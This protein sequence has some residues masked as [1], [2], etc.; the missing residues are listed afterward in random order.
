MHIATWIQSR[1]NPLIKEV[2]ALHDKKRRAAAGLFFFEG[3]K[4]FS[5]A[6]RRGVSL[7]TV[8]VTPMAAQ[9]Y[10]RVLQAFVSIQPHAN[11]VGV[12]DTVYQKMSL[13]NAPQG[14]LCVA[15]HIDKWKN[16]TTIKEIPVKHKQLLLCECIQDPGNLGTILRTAAAFGYDGVI[17]SRDCA[18]LENC[19]VIRASMGAVFSLPVYLVPDLCDV[20]GSLRASGK[21]VFAAALHHDAVTPMVLPDL[22][23]CVFVIGSEGQ[24]LRAQTIAACNGCV[25]I[26]M[27]GQTESLNAAAAAAVLMWEQRRAALCLQPSVK[28]FARNTAEGS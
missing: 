10:A 14:I 1:Q 22:T 4:L 21:T 17:L 8:F 20:I 18:D 9:R 7:R 19:K 12:H 16:C 23:R 3:Y 13:E 6:F 2:C 15:K 24:G 5:E 27:Q 26:P 28:G 25:T 11:V